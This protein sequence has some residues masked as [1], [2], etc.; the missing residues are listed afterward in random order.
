MKDNET[1]GLA[2]KGLSETPKPTWVTD[3]QPRL[4]VSRA[5]W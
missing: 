5:G 2:R 4:S 3:H 1:K